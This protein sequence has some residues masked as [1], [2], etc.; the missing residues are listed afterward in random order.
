MTKDQKKEA[1]LVGRIKS[2]I[3]AGY[4]PDDITKTLGISIV[5]FN[6]YKKMIDEYRSKQN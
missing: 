3:D 2:M 6:A 5:T 1:L 4:T